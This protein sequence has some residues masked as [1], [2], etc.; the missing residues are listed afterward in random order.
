MKYVEALGILKSGG[1]AS[2]D[3]FLPYLN[4]CFNTAVPD[5]DPRLK[6]SVNDAIAVHLLA[7][8]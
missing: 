4:I 1:R 7:A 2:V 6:H 3:P 8:G 5:Q